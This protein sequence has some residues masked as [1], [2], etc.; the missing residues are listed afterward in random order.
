M[1]W[2]EVKNY[3]KNT[4]KYDEDANGLISLAFNLPGG[5]SQ[6][7]VIG[8]AKSQ[9]GKEW[10]KFTSAIGDVPAS[11]L[12]KVLLYAFQYNGGAIAA[13]AEDL[14]VVT[15]SCLLSSFSTEE[16]ETIL[17]TT[18]FLADGIEKDILGQDKY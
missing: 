4:Y 7:A 13:L 10:I 15:N 14:Y 1:I 8:F 11:L 17:E 18:L 5:R 3:I 12:P 2:D 6:R 9:N 16:F